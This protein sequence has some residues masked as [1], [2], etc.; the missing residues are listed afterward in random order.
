MVAVTFFA[1]L[2]FFRHSFKKSR[3]MAAGKIFADPQ[4][5][6]FGPR[7]GLPAGRNIS[8]SDDMGEGITAAQRAE[9]MLQSKVLGFLERQFITAFQLDS[10]RKIVTSIAPIPA[11]YA[12]MPGTPGA[13]NK[14]HQLAISANQEVGRNPQRMNPA[15]IRMGI[16]VEPIGKEPLDRVAAKYTWWEADGMNDDQ[17][18]RLPRRTIVAIR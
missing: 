14:L 3:R 7:I 17:L 6:K 8:M 13:G 16:R 11:R 2:S 4:P 12:R 1:S 9:Q 10:E 15:E 5:I 18:N